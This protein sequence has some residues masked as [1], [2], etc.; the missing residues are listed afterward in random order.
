M[1]C[2]YFESQQ[3]RADSQ[4]TWHTWHVL[5]NMWYVQHLRL[6]DL[7]ISRIVSHCV[8][9]WCRCKDS[10][11]DH[12]VQWIIQPNI[13][14]GRFI[15][16]LQLA[17]AAQCLWSAQICLPYHIRCIKCH[18]G[19]SRQCWRICNCEL[20]H[21]WREILCLLCWT[22]LCPRWDHKTLLI[23]CDAK[24]FQDDSLLYWSLWLRHACSPTCMHVHMYKKSLK[25][26]AWLWAHHTRW[27]PD[28]KL[29]QNSTVQML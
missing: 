15:G 26:H 11:L 29:H 23:Q 14:S 7:G 10:W 27:T 1:L 21:I 13:C 24:L 16:H 3:S 8:Q 19:W 20:Q 4:Q 5:N 22:T 25:P 12:P 2:V 18:I 17:R 9:I 6:K 28:Y